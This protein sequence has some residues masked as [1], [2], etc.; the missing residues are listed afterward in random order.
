M[1][2]TVRPVKRHWK[3]KDPVAIVAQDEGPQSRKSYQ[4][5]KLRFER[6]SVTAEKIAQAEGR[7]RAY[8]F[9]LNYDNPSQTRDE[10]MKP[11]IAAH[12]D[13]PVIIAAVDVSA[14]APGAKHARRAHVHG[15]AWLPPRCLGAIW[16]IKRQVNAGFATDARPWHLEPVKATK[17]GLPR[18]LRYCA[19]CENLGRSGSMPFADL[20]TE[21]EAALV[22]CGLDG[23]KPATAP[24]SDGEK[25]SPS[26]AR[27]SARIERCNS[28]IPTPP[29]EPTKTRAARTPAEETNPPD[30][31]SPAAS[32]AAGD[33]TTRRAGRQRSTSVPEVV[34]DSPD[35]LPPPKSRLEPEVDLGRPI[36]P[37]E[38]ASPVCGQ[39]TGEATMVV[40]GHNLFD[41]IAVN[42]SDWH[43]WKSGRVP[44]SIR[45]AIARLRRI[46][47]ATTDQLAALVGVSQS[48]LEHCLSP[49]GRGDPLSI[50][51]VARLK[52]W[53]ISNPPLPCARRPP[54]KRRATRAAA[55][56]QPPLF[57]SLS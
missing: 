46:R 23:E 18:W 43:S 32:A 22:L 53:I 21:A 6:L 38:P 48:H 49:T 11:F 25:R 50:N 2:P 20:R 1:A 26:R 35:A 33:N 16:D 29:T 57:R 28:D 12:G 52:F 51:A 36:A 55:P 30:Q 14:S 45:L 8:I 37:A 5:R 44:L 40:L 41:P 42:A 54:A 10:L 19:S 27:E 39:E 56:S 17:G 24:V 7:M 13:E 34:G 31:P 47:G 4:D 15:A 3:V 9:T